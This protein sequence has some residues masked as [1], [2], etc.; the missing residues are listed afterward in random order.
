MKS[1]PLFAHFLAS[2]TLASPILTRQEPSDVLIPEFWTFDLLSWNG[3]GCPDYPK[4]NGTETD[5]SFTRQ[6]IG[7]YLFNSS[8]D[9][10]WFYFAYPW[11][12]VRLSDISGH[13]AKSNNTWC[14]S[15]IKYQEMANDYGTRRKEEESKYRLRMHKNGTTIEAV[16]KLRD[17][18]SAEWKVTYLAENGDE[19]L[20]SYPL[21]INS[22]KTVHADLIF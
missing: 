4:Y 3:P 5:N 8:A 21:R 12:R 15:T 19:V 1:K 7:P 20:V 16:Y 10:W 14:E 18:M 2:T 17:G 11:M 22:T 9:T 6:S 13:A